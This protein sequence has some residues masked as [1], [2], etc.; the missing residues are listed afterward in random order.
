MLLYNILKIRFLWQIRGLSRYSDNFI[1]AMFNPRYRMIGLNPCLT[2]FF[3]P[4]GRKRYSPL[5]LRDDQKPL[6]NFDV[7]QR[8]AGG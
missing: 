8:R 6:I 4:H 3:G 1:L 7:A 2:G 5:W